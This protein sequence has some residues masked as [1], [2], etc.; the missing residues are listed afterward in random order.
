[1][2]AAYDEAKRNFQL[3][4]HRLTEVEGG[5]FCEA[6]LRMLQQ[7]ALGRFT[8][9]GRH[10]DTERVIAALGSTPVGSQP[11]AIRLHIP[12]AIRLV[13][14]IRNARDAAH[15]GDD[16]DSNV[17][18]ATIVVST[19]DWIMAEFLRLDHAVGPDRA[20]SIIEDL[21]TR[22]VP[23]VEDLDGFRKVLRSDL[24][25]SAFILLLLYAAGGDGSTFAQLESWARA[26]MRAN[27][28][29]TLTG[30]DDEA[31]I[32]YDGKKYRITAKGKREVERK[33]FFDSQ[34]R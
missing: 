22:L 9:L 16:I 20:Q 34:V 31:F 30:L 28:R 29:R 15:L 1:L 33:R 21:V 13:Y 11:D 4:G 7:R 32:H 26:S 10:V 5:R 24:R 2:L 25:A 17:Q 6:A 8:P 18:D 3:G 19:L 12:R 23:A 14:D 27:L